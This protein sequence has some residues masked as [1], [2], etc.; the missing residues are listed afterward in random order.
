[1]SF[2]SLKFRPD[3]TVLAALFCSKLRKYFVFVSPSS[4]DL[5]LALT[6]APL[7]L[8]N[9]CVFRLFPTCCTLFVLVRSYSGHQQFFS[10]YLLN[11]FLER[12]HRAVFSSVFF[13]LPN[14]MQSVRIEAFNIFQHVR[15]SRFS[16][17]CSLKHFSMNAFI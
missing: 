13:L 14:S 4:I 1:M 10:L 3:P 11:W 12:E 6:M 2:G 8:A 16:S 15:L 7:V 9:C 5:T 17:L